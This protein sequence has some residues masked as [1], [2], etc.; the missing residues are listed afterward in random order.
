MLK[1]CLITI[2]L[3]QT[4]TLTKQTSDNKVKNFGKANGLRSIHNASAES[5]QKNDITQ[6]K[7]KKG[8][9]KNAITFEKESQ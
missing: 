6:H 3:K 7:R 9:Y 1:N 5:V 4:L 8:F 2:T